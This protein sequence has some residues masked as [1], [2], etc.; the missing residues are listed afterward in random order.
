MEEE[1]KEAELTRV[2]T[3]LHHELSHSDKVLC[4]A[5]A[6]PVSSSVSILP[7][8]QVPELKLST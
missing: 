1:E 6:K 7:L 4:T 3:D 5:L 2:S 8:H